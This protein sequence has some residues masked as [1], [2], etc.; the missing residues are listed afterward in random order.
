MISVKLFTVEKKDKSLNAHYVTLLLT[1]LYLTCASFYSHAQL[2]NLAPDCRQATVAPNL[3]WPPNN[4]FVPLQIQGITDPENQ[5]VTVV[6]Q[7]I[8]QDEPIKPWRWYRGKYDGKGLTTDSP[9]VRAKRRFWFFDWH[10][11]KWVKSNGRVYDVVFKATDSEG[12]MCSGKVTVGVPQRK[13]K[14]VEDNGGRYP[15]LPGG[16]NCQALPINN[17]PIIV[18]T[19]TTEAQVNT[20]YQTTIVGHDPDQDTL[21]YALVT[22]PA[23]MAVDAATGL[24]QWTPT[25]EQEGVQSIEVEVSD[26]GGLTATQVFDM[27]VTSAIDELS[28]KIIANPVTG[29]SPLTVRFSSD[30]Q[31]NNIVITGYAWDFDGDGTNDRTDSFGAPQTYTY[32]GNPGDTFQATLTIAVNSGDPLVATQTITIENEL[33]A[34]QVATNITNGHAPLLVNFTVTAQ[35]PQGIAEVSIDYEGDGTFDAM[36]AGNSTPSG[37]WTFQTTYQD[38]GTYVAV[39]RVTDTAGAVT[40]VTNN[41][42]TVDVNDPLDPII[43]LSATPLSGNVPLTGNLSASAEL[44]DGS[45]ITQ[46]RWDLDGNGEFETQGG[47]GASDTVSFTYSGVNNFYPVVEVTTDSGRTAKASLRIEVQSTARP[48]LSIPDTSD[49]INSDNGESAVFTVTLPFETELEVWLENSSGGRVKTVQ[50]PTVTAAGDYDF[51]WDATDEQSSA[52]SEG[53]YYAVIGYTVFG[54]QQEVDLRTS[55]GGQLSYYRRT[56]ANPRTFD[57]IEGPLRINYAVDNPAEVSF[58]WQISFGARLMT[59]LEREPSGRGQYSLYWNGAFPNGQKIPDNLQT[60]MPGI[61]RYV[62]PDNVIFVKETPRIENFTLSSTVIWDPRREPI[63]L[64]L[65]LS[66]SSTIEIVVAD[67][68]KGVDVATQVFSDIDAGEQTLTWDG[69]NNDEQYLAPGDYRIGVRSVDSRGTRSLY[70]FRTQHID[71]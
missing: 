19:A 67:M 55:T 45:T 51:S 65:T 41:A 8:T 60:L 39:V 59:L 14:P 62:L 40:V 13:K 57:R 22:A 7:C 36:Q 6:T 42:I 66:K 18:S 56:T 29:L 50:L 47:S 10:N 15:T 16:Q 26:T 5:A 20:A 2:L 71:Y 38:Q 28:A 33:P 54:Q 21:A 43:Q 52:V 17:P 61:V 31:N 34:V 27:T 25:A 37:S 44:F 9:E 4:K 53:D 68:E 63:G 23:G 48:S 1:G 46:W 12:A 3:I 64:N 69:K 35:D 32:T 30:V 11:W 58:F 24:I 49:T 70:W